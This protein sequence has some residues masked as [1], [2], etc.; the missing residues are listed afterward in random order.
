MALRY[1]IAIIGD[2]GVGKSSLLSRI[3]E[4]TFSP[5]YA[6][7]LGADV[8]TLVLHTNYGD[9]IFDCWDT[10][11][12]EKFAGLGEGYWVNSEGAIAMFD[13]SSRKSHNNL[14]EFVNKYKTVAI[15]TP[16]VICGNKIELNRE[17]QPSAK[18]VDI[19][20]KN[21]YNC[22]TPFVELAIKLTGH[23]DL[24]FHF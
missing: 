16:I 2:G 4:N 8:H 10:A 13:V 20:V 1:K 3:L 6:A 17:V 12:Q 14:Q 11:G 7:T 21:N 15:N 19:S 24:K 5:R 18:Y 9:I 22:I 23:L